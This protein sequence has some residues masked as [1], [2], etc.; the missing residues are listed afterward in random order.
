[1]ALLGRQPT[2][3]FLKGLSYSVRL[4]ISCIAGGLALR[5]YDP[6]R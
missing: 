3:A 6:A 1:M 2:S 5:A 4:A